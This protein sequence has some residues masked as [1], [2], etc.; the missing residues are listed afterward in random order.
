MR[1]PSSAESN[2]TLPVGVD[3]WRVFVGHGQCHFGISGDVYRSAGPE[4]STHHA[5]QPFA[6]HELHNVGDGNNA[7]HA[8]FSTGSMGHGAHAGS[9]EPLPAHCLFCLD[10]LAATGDTI[11][12][13]AS[14]T[15][16]PRLPPLTPYREFSLELPT[17][18]RLTGSPCTSPSALTTD[19]PLATGQ[20]RGESL[21]TSDLDKYLKIWRPRCNLYFAGQAYA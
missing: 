14:F 1:N 8:L 21:V 19:D 4:D 2:R 17:P 3:F 9:N 18:P 13:Y 10:G 12:W 15:E 5:H 20:G 7:A 16:P 6:N 11:P